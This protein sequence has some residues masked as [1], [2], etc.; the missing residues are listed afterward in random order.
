MKKYLLELPT[1][2][3]R[4]LKSTVA[5]EDTTI[6]D[7][8]IAAIREKLE[9]WHYAGNGEWVQNKVKPKER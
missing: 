1:E 7:Y 3:H 9:K 4:D 6:K 2:L 5:M 8:I